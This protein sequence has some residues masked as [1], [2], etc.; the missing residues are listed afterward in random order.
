MTTGFVTV[1][2]GALNTEVGSQPGLEQNLQERERGRHCELRASSDSD[3]AGSVV[4]CWEP[5]DQC[6]DSAGTVIGDIAKGTCHIHINP[7]DSY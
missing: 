5:L 7:S 3:V 6:W 4:G 1:A 2:L